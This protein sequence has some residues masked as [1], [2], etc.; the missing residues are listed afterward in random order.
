M[1]CPQTGVAIRAASKLHIAKNAAVMVNLKKRDQATYHAARPA[2]ATAS[3]GI[4]RTKAAAPNPMTPAERGKDEHEAI[5]D[6]IP[7]G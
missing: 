7:T 1:T 5:H 3:N 2:K 4:G 6:E